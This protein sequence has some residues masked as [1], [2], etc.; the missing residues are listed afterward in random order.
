MASQAP[1]VF[2]YPCPPVRSSVQGMLGPS[3]RMPDDARRYNTKAAL[4]YQEK[5]HRFRIRPG[6]T[7]YR[8]AVVTTLSGRT[9]SYNAE[10]CV[11][12]FISSPQ[13]ATTVG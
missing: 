3:N 8:L 12:R 6:P 4:A 10:T 11:E 7:G 13:T 2:R 5:K 1:S 9:G